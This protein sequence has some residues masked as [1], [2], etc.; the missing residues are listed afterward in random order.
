MVWEVW[1]AESRKSSHVLRLA[2]LTNSVSGIVAPQFLIPGRPA[3][4]L[5]TLSEQL[6]SANL[7][8][9]C[10]AIGGSAG[11]LQDVTTVHRF[12]RLYDHMH[13]VLGG[14]NFWR[15]LIRYAE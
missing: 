7:A 13:I 10:L 2:N 9:L 4:H 12:A 15:G 11:V 3:A 8:G 6:I 5:Y 14:V 1:N